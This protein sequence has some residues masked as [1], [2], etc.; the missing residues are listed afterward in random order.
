MNIKDNTHLTTS[1]REDM[2]DL[3]RK[4]IDEAMMA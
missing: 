1:G 3:Y 4:M 2:T